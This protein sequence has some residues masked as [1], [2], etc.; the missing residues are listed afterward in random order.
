VIYSWQRNRSASQYTLDDLEPV[1]RKTARELREHGDKFDAIVVTG[2]SGVVVGAPVALRLKKPLVI[3]RKS[4]DNTHHR[5]N[6]GVIGYKHIHKSLLFLDDFED[7]GETA[8]RVRTA[9]RAG[10]GHVVG[11]YYYHAGDANNT[12]ELEWN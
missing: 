1:V 7:S 3:L 11:K 2:M 9:V 6:R 12:S 4:G 10:G 5:R 8:R